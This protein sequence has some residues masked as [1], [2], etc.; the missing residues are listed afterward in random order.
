MTNNNF[1]I[2]KKSRRELSRGYRT[3]RFIYGIV[4]LAL[5]IILAHRMGVNIFSVGLIVI[6]L[7]SSIYIFLKKGLFT[8]TKRMTLAS[9]TIRIKKS[10]ERV[11]R[12]ELKKVKQIKIQGT[13]MNIDFDD[14][15][16]YYD[17]SWLSEKEFSEFKSQLA[18]RCKAHSVPLE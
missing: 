4:L 11:R 6:G 18:G 7:A 8:Y 16:R 5:G 2:E 14:Y 13:G 12:I 3:Y 9:D 1:T 15:S 10:L 17:L